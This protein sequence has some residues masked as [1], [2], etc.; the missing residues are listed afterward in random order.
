M[1]AVNQET[2]DGLL[3]CLDEAIVKRDKSFKA[4]DDYYKNDHGH[5]LSSNYEEYKERKDTIIKTFNIHAL[6]YQKKLDVLCKKVRNKQ[7]VLNELN[8]EN[9]NVTD[10]FPRRIALGKYHVQY[11]NL[12]FFVPKMFEFPFKKPMYICDDNQ[13]S[14]LHKILLRLMYALPIDKQE[15]YVFDPMG[16]GKSVW[17]FNKLFSNGK[18]FPQKKIMSTAAE[19]KEVLKNEENYIAS[20][21]KNT[22]NLQLDCQ[23]WDSYNRRVQSQGNSQKM[24]PH[25]TFIFLDVPNGMDSECFEMF[26][27]ILGHSEKCGFLVLFSFNKLLLEAEENK[28]KTQELQ[29]K[30]RIAE[31]L[32]LHVVLDKNISES[33]FEELTINS[34]GEKFPDDK[35]LSSLL[36]DFDEELN[37][38]NS[39]MFSFD[40]ILSDTLLFNKSSIEALYIPC[41]YT[42]SGGGKVELCVGDRY[43]HYLIGG[44]TGSGKSNLLH[45]IIMSACWNYSPEE[46]SIYLMDFKEGVEFSI[47]AKQKLRHAA[48]VATEADTEYGVSV[49][50][51][52]VDEKTRRY[53]LFKKENCKDIQAYRKKKVA[54]VMPRILVVVDEFQVLFNNNEKDKTIETLSMLAKQGRACGIHLILAT[55]SL[56]GLDFGTLAPQFSGRIAL[57]CS[58]EDSKLLLGGIT[59]NNE[60][61]AELEIPYAILNTSQGSVSGN[62]RYAVPEAKTDEMEKKINFINEKCNQERISTTTKIFEGQTFPAFP[63]EVEFI[64]SLGMSITLGEDI[65]YEAKKRVLK[66]QSA[67]ENNLLFCGHDEQMKYDFIKEILFSAEYCPE[68]EEL[69]YIGEEVLPDYCSTFKIVKYKNAK[70]FLDVESGTYFNK[71][72]F[73]FINNSN[74]KKDVGFPPASYGTPNEYA[75]KFKEFWDD[76]NKNGTHIIALYDGINRIKNCELP[77]QDFRYRVGYSLNSEEQNQLLGN[78]SFASKEPR[79]KRAFF[80]DNLIIEC[81][82]RPFE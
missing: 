25:K 67:P 27:H 36:T 24:L 29:L 43:P 63:S 74:M 41:G 26:N 18:L 59:S 21:Y 45:N 77:M 81:W 62:V 73:I 52:L 12:D 37:K 53:D 5:I 70:E 3:K 56:K 60:E 69:V 19:L 71:K 11:K 13:M 38:H 78:T 46:L 61:A 48:L 55:Q 39:S 68:C 58:S 47:Y 2:I 1:S 57:K 66:M 16:F 82:F 22:F 76:A 44:T 51:H 4:L 65:S 54:E 9:I 32:P 10:R 15:Y 50:S 35:K 79:K 49:L 72:R 64:N 34:V 14:L 20:L 28:I 8:H 33:T 23:D 30:Q 40:E 6:D 75:K 17:K 42:V 31:S 80:A 7:P